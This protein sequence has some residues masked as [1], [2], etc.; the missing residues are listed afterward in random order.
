MNRVLIL[1]LL[2]V[3]ALLGMMELGAQPSAVI[4][5]LG[6]SD[7]TVAID[8]EDIFTRASTGLPNVGIGEM[9][10]LQGA[11]ANAEENISAWEWTLVDRPNN[12]QAQL[13]SSDQ[14]IVTLVPDIVG[15]YRVQLR[16]TT[17]QGQSDPV[18]IPINAAT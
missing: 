3:G 14:P 6:V 13:S 11:S 7:R 10:Y 18:V 16:I 2:V 4:K 9:V 5:V 15:T 12:S 8:P 1:S 17:E